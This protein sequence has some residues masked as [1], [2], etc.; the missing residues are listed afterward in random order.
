MQ[1][2]G[3]E[4]S[5]GSLPVTR[6]DEIGVLA[7]AFAR[8]SSERADSMATIRRQHEQLAASNAALERRVSD[9]THE[10]LEKNSHLEREIR[11]RK[12]AEA[13]VAQLFRSLNKPRKASPC[14]MR[15]VG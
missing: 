1:R 9:R 6:E 12:S 5:P 2:F 11:E 15:P 3:A 7:R 14:A 13:Q 8:M 10:V 4:E